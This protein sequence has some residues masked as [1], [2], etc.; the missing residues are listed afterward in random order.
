M[1]ETRELNPCR[2]FT[3]TFSTLLHQFVVL[4]VIIGRFNE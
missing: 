3:F 2:L 1:L 4:A